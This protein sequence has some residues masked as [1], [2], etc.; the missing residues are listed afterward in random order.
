[1]KDPNLK[2]SE[3][4]TNRK[5][6][7]I[8]LDTK[9]YGTFAEIGAGQEVAR[10]FFTAGGA[11]GTIAKS[12]SAYDMKFSDT[13]YGKAHRYVSKER[14]LQMLDHEYQLIIE[15]LDETRGKDTAFF[16]L[17]NTVATASYSYHKPGNGWMGMRFQATP[18]SEPSDI[19][20]H[21]R[22]LD[23]TPIAQQE[24]LGIIGVNFVWATLVYYDDVDQ[25][26]AS[27]TDNIENARIE[28]D[29]L[30]FTGPLF[31]KKVENRVVSL[32]LVEK[33]LTN[34]VMFSPSGE[35]LLPSDALY[36]KSVLVERGSF[37]PVT[38][39]NVD[40]MKY[41]GVQFAQDADQ[42]PGTVAQANAAKADALKAGSA[43]AKVQDAA[44][45][46]PEEIMPLFEMTV[47]NLLGDNKAIDYT[48][49]LSRVDSI[50]ALGYNTLVS[51]YMEYYR[52]SAYFRRYTD[53]RIGIVLGINHLRAV[54]EED[55][56]QNLDGGILESFGRM[57]KARV[58]LYVYP[59]KAKGFRTYITDDIP[60]DFRPTKSRDLFDDSTVLTADNLHVD[61]HLRH[62]YAYLL[63]NH[64]IE[65]VRDANLDNLD[66]ISRDVYA[67]IL[68]GNPK[69]EEHV[70]EKAAKV[71]KEKKLWHRS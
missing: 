21:I 37:R 53:K 14:L 61:N 44:A 40:M 7:L 63:E 24:A 23:A 26:I 28:V 42:N 68:E 66:I 45:Q 58:K 2:P 32:K 8:N 54:F 47:N 1:M 29:S 10:H 9:V 20:I 17:A 49:F 60:E 5:A 65:P 35:T 13:I 6:L 50:S 48:D 41:A 15:R 18:E 56:Y 70:P 12:M 30:E 64:F 51:N 39:V 19:L 46:E 3:L 43:P 4:T 36:K 22:M 62:L 27:L 57:F 25:F 59:M 38:H 67:H 31:R 11:A 71:I 33:G 55:Y 16:V 52:L 69:W 34:A